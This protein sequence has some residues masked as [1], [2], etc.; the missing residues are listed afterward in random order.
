M[1]TISEYGLGDMLVT[2]V[3]NEAGQVGMTLI[4]AA[5]KDRVLQKDWALQSLA[6]VHFRGDPLPNAYAN[7]QS[8][9][10]TRSTAGMIFRR[11]WREENR[12]L[13]EMSDAQGRKII[14]TL[15]WQPGSPAFR[16][17]VCF[18]NGS[19]RPVTLDLLTSLNLGQI[20]PFTPGDACGALSLF[21]AR[22]NWSAEGRFIRES[23]EELSLEPSWARHGYRVE[24]FGQIGSMPVRHFFPFLAVQDSRAGV[25]WA[26]QL[27][28]PSSW[29]FEIRR[30]DDGM[31]VS[32][33]L[34]DGDYGHWS[35]TLRPGERLTSP[36]AYCTVSTEDADRTAQRL[37]SIHREQWC[38]KDDP[39]PVLFNEYCT[40]WGNPSHEN[41]SRIISCLRGKD[42]DY[43]VID[44]GWY[45]K[46]GAGWSDCSGDWIPSKALFPRG[47]GAV[48]G[49]IRSAGMKPGLWFEPET[50]ACQS[51]LFK[52]EDLL[53]KRDGAVLDTDNRRF[54]DLRKP[55]AQ[56]FLD[57]RVIG[58]LKDN[59]FSYVKIDYNDCIGV[60]CD[61]PD[62][63][64]EGLRRNM[65]G[66]QDFFRRMKERVPDLMIENCSS[67]GHR[68]EPSMLAVSDIASFSD[69]HECVEIPIIAASLHRLMLPGQ[70][71]IWAVMRK[72]DSL[73]RIGYSL[74]NTYLGVMCLSGD[75]A[76]LSGEQWKAVEESIRFYREVQD[77][78]RDGV[79]SFFGSGQQSWRHPRGWQAVLRSLGRR[80]LLVAHS[81]G[82]E[83]SSLSV[84]IPAGGAR[85][86][87][88]FRTEE[89]P[90]AVDQDGLHLTFTAP[91][92]AVALEL[93]ED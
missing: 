14:H 92:Q 38:R 87:R 8:L 3:T 89:I 26:F 78:I 76:D 62:G 4:P 73:R 85:V 54:L 51:D 48:A 58:L 34:A 44:A 47:I 41:L 81:F 75:I 79:S 80:S 28:C 21:R 5:L 67:G 29:Q 16:C 19:D 6:E 83:G 64:G 82:F 31:T 55:E 33:G 45:L 30:K 93:R 40:T 32:A 12:I 27:A 86:E 91:F 90:V 11:Q 24:K 1:K 57:E 2:Y 46:E 35:K 53:L 36:E 72:T 25:T 68:L 13:T 22:S 69:A 37:L 66:T 7:G 77:I 61:D 23:A 60:G 49:E 65:L 56:A 71:Q 15:T 70:S 20:T 9:A 59:G 10:G 74:I 39:L 17:G 52:R 43:L 84:R 42:I 88:I 63:L 18:E 50:C